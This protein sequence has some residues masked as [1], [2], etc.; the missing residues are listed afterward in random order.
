MQLKE[1]KQFVKGFV[2][3]LKN[4]K[5]V[6]LTL[7]QGLGVNSI[8]ELRKK[9]KEAD[10]EMR[11]VKNRLALRAIEEAGIESYFDIKEFFKGPVA[12]LL[13]NEDPS[14][15][16]KIFKGY[17]DENKL[18]EF[19]A[20]I[21]MDTFMNSSQIEKIADLPSKDVMIAKTVY[22]LNAPIQGLC[23]SLAGIIKKALY[24]LNDL[25][26]VKGKE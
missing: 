18:M 10:C 17:V 15:A 21:I 22:A 24:A 13:G 26:S 1:K 2:E 19:K 14:K 9:L 6:I 7:Y 11:V 12:V 8:N 5:S 23:N 3:E 20:A 25:K 16:I 4:S